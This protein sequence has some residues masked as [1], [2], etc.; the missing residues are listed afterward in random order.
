M[1]NDPGPVPRGCQPSL[2]LLSACGYALE[3]QIRHPAPQCWV[4]GSEAGWARALRAE[5]APSSPS[6]PSPAASSAAVGS[7]PPAEAEQAWPQS[8]GEEELQL[9]LALAMSKEEADQ[10]G[11]CPPQPCAR[12]P[13]PTPPVLPLPL[14]M[15][16]PLSLSG[17]ASLACPS[18]LSRHLPSTVCL[19][20]PLTLSPYLL[21]VL[22]HLAFSLPFSRSFSRSLLSP[23][24]LL[25]GPGA[26]TLSPQP[27][28]C[29]PEDDVQLQL[30]LSLSREEHDK[31]REAPRPTRTPSTAGLPPPRVSPHSS[32]TPSV[33]PG[34]GA[35]M[36]SGCPG[37][38]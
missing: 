15:L 34:L 33:L 36:W 6:P 17:L 35:G 24:L 22:F 29:G 23:S 16:P 31:V 4:L 32:S 5:P 12:H 37:R 14:G 25:P 11:P 38:H 26:H 18:N 2:T 9:Q 8:S 28:S 7:G 10:V 13:P 21:P 3:C 19:S 20:P 27:P 1:G 30:A